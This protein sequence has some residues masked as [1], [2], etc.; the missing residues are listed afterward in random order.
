MTS[1]IE[2]VLRYAQG[3]RFLHKTSCLAAI[4]LAVSLETLP[5]A[6]GETYRCS[7][8]EGGIERTEILRRV[9][10]ANLFFKS[11]FRRLV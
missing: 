9:A 4:A 8:E 7:F 1:H 11:A 6:H 2:I 10:A 3:M 5:H